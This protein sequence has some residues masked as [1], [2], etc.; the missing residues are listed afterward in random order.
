MRWLCFQ[1]DVLSFDMF[2]PLF[3]SVV[4]LR[5]VVDPKRHY[6]AN[7]TKGVPKFFQVIFVGLKIEMPIEKLIL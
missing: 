1:H 5:G 4:Q 7:D 3:Y 2:S 6:K